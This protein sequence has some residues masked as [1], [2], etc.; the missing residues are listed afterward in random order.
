LRSGSYSA[1]GAK[2]WSLT[3]IEQTLREL[4]PL[5]VRCAV[6][7]STFGSGFSQL[8]QPHANQNERSAKAA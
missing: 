3:A 8:F 1:G 7:N 6:F 4:D 2:R 5:Q